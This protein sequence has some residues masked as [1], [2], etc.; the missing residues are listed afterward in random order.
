[1]SDALQD[2]DVTESVGGF[3]NRVFSS[4]RYFYK[5][6]PFGEGEKLDFPKERIALETVVD[7]LPASARHL[8]PR[9]AMVGKPEGGLGQVTAYSRLPGFHPQT[10]DSQVAS[11]LGGFLRD[12]HDASSQR[13]IHEFENIDSA[14]SFHDYVP[15]AIE[16]YV[17]K[18]F[19]R[20]DDPDHISIATKAA[21]QAV[22]MLESAAAPE[23]VL[24]HKDIHARNL[25]CSDGRL[26]GIIDW[27]ACQ[28][29]PREWEFAILR[30][31]F[32]ES[33]QRVRSAYGLELDR[34]V[35]DIAGLVQS[36]RF[37][38]SFPHDPVFV[39]SQRDYISGILE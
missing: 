21:N 38:K 32:P 15:S 4:D 5:I 33:W 27:E 24:I 19:K 6:T 18:L 3:S 14:L 17:G 9:V 8:V 23:L 28:S 2:G 26:S 39:R 10:I 34:K 37:W 22:A 7:V 16:K 12:L 35:M 30:Q 31:R 13:G 29:G 36:L 25:L 11:D 20:V 1:M